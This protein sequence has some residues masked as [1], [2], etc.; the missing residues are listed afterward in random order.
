MSV[1]TP[2]GRS[3][4]QTT[5]DPFTLS[6]TIEV[7]VLTKGGGDPKS[8]QLRPLYPRAPYT[9]EQIEVSVLTK[10]GG[11]PNPDNFAHYTL[12]NIVLIRLTLHYRTDRGVSSHNVIKGGGSQIQTTSHYTLSNIFFLLDWCVG[13][14]KGVA[15]PNPDNFAPNFA[16]PRQLRYPIFSLSL[17][18]FGA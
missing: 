16:I 17:T 18:E 8:R 5:P 7:S 11:L 2:G 15:I 12:S 3:Q 4:I 1:L 14:H 10:G 9:I 13:S 6:N